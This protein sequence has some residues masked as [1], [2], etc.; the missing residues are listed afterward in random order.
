MDSAKSQF[1]KL[2]NQ[3]LGLVESPKVD[4]GIVE[5]PQERPQS[6]LDK[7][8][9]MLT[10]VSKWTPSAIKSCLHDNH[11]EQEAVPVQLDLKAG[12]QHD[13]RTSKER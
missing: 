9:I 3:D 8:L 1:N 13:I 12:G 11:Q 4:V 7:V 5:A 2:I 6:Q 10:K